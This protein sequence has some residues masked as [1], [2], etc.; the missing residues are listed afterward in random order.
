MDPEVIRQLQDSLQDLNDVL[1]RQNTSLSNLVKSINNANDSLIKNNKVAQDKLKAELAAAEAADDLADAY[2]EAELAEKAR[3]EASKTTYDILGSSLKSFTDALLSGESNLTKF[4]GS[5]EGLGKAVFAFTA[6]TSAMGTAAG[7]AAIGLTKLYSQAFKLDDNIIK[8]RDSFAET[9]GVL[10]ATSKEIGDFAKAAGYSLGDIEKLSKGINKLGPNLLALGGNAGEGAV[11]MMKVAEVGEKTY[12]RFNKMGYSQEDVLDMQSKYIEE[13]AASGQSLELRRKDEK[14]I[15][16]ESIA[17]ADNLV[18]MQTLTGKKAEQLQ[19]DRQKAINEYEEQAAEAAENAE[20]KRLEREGGAAN[21][22]K[23]E[24]IKKERDA[25]IAMIEEVSDQI[26]P[27]TAMQYAHLWRKGAYDETTLGMASVNAAADMQELKRKFT[28]DKKEIDKTINLVTQKTQD[29]MVTY[30]GAVQF[31]GSNL[32]KMFNITND[33]LDKTNKKESDSLAAR[34]RAEDDINKK[35]ADKTDKLGNTIAKLLGLDR[36]AKSTFQSLLETFD[37]LRSALGMLT[38]GILALSV[39]G[40]T[41]G[42]GKTLMG[43]AGMFAKGIGGA[44]AAGEAAG[45]AALDGLG[46]VAGTSGPAVGLFLE[47]LATGFTA[48]GEAAGPVLIGAG[49]AAGIVTLLGAGVAAAIAL[50]G[51]SLKAF[52]W[53]LSSFEKLNGNNLDLLGKGML[54]LGIGMT[55]LGAG[56]V[57]NAFGDVLNFFGKMTG[58]T[59]PIKNLFNQLLVLQQYDL[60]SSKVENN[61]RTLVSFF[62][63]LSSYKGGPGLL[64]AIS[65]LFGEGLMKLTGRKGPIEMF[66]DFAKTD[67]G[68]RAASNAEAFKKY[69]ESLQM[70]AGQPAGTGGAPSGGGGAGG[71]PAASSTPILDAAMAAGKA[72]IAT[73]QGLVDMGTRAY[74]VLTAKPDESVV[75]TQGK[76]VKVAK[77]AA[78]KFQA[79]LDYMTKIGYKINSLGGYANRDV[80]GRAGV[81]SAH[82]RGWAIDVNPKENPLQEGSGPVKTDIPAEVVSFAK[83]Q[84]LGWG[85]AWRSRRD[86]MHFSAQKNEGGQFEPA[87]AA[88]GGIFANG[89]DAQLPKAQKLAALNTNSILMKLAKTNADAARGTAGN[90]AGMENIHDQA[91]L[92]LEL[93]NM[94][95]GKLSFVLNALEN[96]HSV[97]NKIYK[98]SMV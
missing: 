98:H 57:L 18:L 20:I 78:P 60:D 73:G 24:E 97:H 41:I 48:L 14:T 44:G 55:A 3:I 92:T 17:Y 46:K 4:G 61:S 54:S 47:G 49:V 85:G 64:T 50:V 28:T 74:N 75:G 72:V 16:K 43:K 68:P 62:N 38:A 15:T 89:Y 7:L 84:G 80:V 25:R 32:G 79:T 31:G 36:A 39:G 11:K 77:E 67:F 81:K 5:I 8:F 53:G 45:G 94:I 9:A 52:A 90:A 56:K 83:S 22:A 71:A 82:S 30:A 2:K 12:Q 93:Y 76:S 66:K 37:P 27:D 23:A 29:N 33:M 51:T 95:D 35:N 65:S 96:S 19:Q 13:Q 40:V 59:D 70:V 42:A 86:A 26:G 88:M 21:L 6:G 63:A 34:N 87:R 10:P 69:A 1:G 58:G 91:S